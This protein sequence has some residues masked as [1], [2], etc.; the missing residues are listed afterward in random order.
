MN[1][2]HTIVFGDGTEITVT[3]NGNNYISETPIDPD[4]LDDLNL[5]GMKIDGEERENMTCCNHFED[6][7]GDHIIFRELNEQDLLIQSLTAKLEYIA[8]M[9]DIE[10]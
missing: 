7:E 1:D 3:M 9:E 4:L 6:E 5:I 8:M 10:L 2:L